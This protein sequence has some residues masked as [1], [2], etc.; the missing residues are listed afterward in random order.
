MGSE[1]CIRD[2][3]WPYRG[4]LLALATI[5]LAGLWT[6]FAEIQKWY[7]IVGAAFLPAVAV[8]L[9][10]LGRRR[11]LVGEKLATRWIGLLALVAVLLFYLLAG[12][13]EVHKRLSGTYAGPAWPTTPCCGLQAA[14]L[15]ED[16]H[17]PPSAVHLAI[18]RPAAAGDTAVG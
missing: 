7:A 8:A 15:T 16:S 6:R 10:V 12:G 4:W 3:S 1:M 2:R 17:D 13:L 9:L 5:P 18:P 11:S 14:P